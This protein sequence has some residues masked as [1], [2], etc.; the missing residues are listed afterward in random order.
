MHPAE[1]KM[2]LEIKGYSQAAV[3][4]ACGVGRSAVGMV[5]NGRGRSKQVEEWIAAATGRTLLE[6]WPQW[7]GEGDPVL[8]SD[9]RELVAAYRKLQPAKRAALLAEA[10]AEYI[11]KPSSHVTADRGSIASGGDVNIGSKS[12]RRGK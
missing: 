2:A 3:A 12:G 6:L 10:R 9:E 5:V 4:T 1:I 7:Y 11:A 8:S